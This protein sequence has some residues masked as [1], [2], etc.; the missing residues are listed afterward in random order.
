MRTVLAFVVLAL[1][2][3][4]GAGAEGQGECKLSAPRVVD[5]SNEDLVWSY[6]LFPSAAA[7]DE[8]KRRGLVRDEYR[9]SIDRKAIEIGMNE[10]EMKAAAFIA[11]PR[12]EILTARGKEVLWVIVGSPVT[13]LTR[14]GVVVAA[15]K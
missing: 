7:W 2:G 10:T 4:G 6:H 11:Y 14:N 5:C 13:V 1:L 12:S 15:M 3:V 9:Q 8:L